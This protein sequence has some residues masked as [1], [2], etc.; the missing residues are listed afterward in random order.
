MATIEKAFD[1]FEK[2]ARRYLLCDIVGVISGHF[3]AIPR[4]NPAEALV[5]RGSRRP[6]LYKRLLRQNSLRGL[7]EIPAEARNVPNNI[8]RVILEFPG[9]TLARWCCQL[10]R[11]YICQNTN[12]RHVDFLSFSGLALTSLFFS[13]NLSTESQKGDYYVQ[14]FSR[15]PL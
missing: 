3:S 6:L 2:E 12:I 11:W 8:R 5:I 14:Q 15:F 9:K 7:R 10:V 13:A 1:Q 4:S